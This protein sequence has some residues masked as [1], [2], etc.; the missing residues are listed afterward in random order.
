MQETVAAA[1]AHLTR[2]DPVA[3]HVAQSALDTLLSGRRLETLTQHAVQEFCWHVLPVR[4]S[5]EPSEW[6]FVTDSL[7]SLFRLL[8]LD[9]YADICV[10]ER[11]REV[12]RAYATS[13]DQG[14]AAYERSMRSSGVIPP[15]LPELT[16]GT[17][18][19]NAEIEAYRETSAVL[20]LAIAAGEVRPGTRG[21]RAAQEERARSFLTQ[22][23][24][25]GLSY[26]D[27]I[28][29]ERVAE[30]LASRSHPH[31]EHLLPLRGQLT[32]GVD[33]PRNA[34]DALAPVQRLLD[35]AAD[36]IALTQIGYISPAVVR[37]LCDEFGWWT[38]PSPPRSETD[39]MQLIVLHKLLR[40]M[41]AVR[42]SGRRL[43]L[44]RH[45]RQLHSDL[46]ELWR[47]VAESV[48]A[49][50]GFEQAAIETLL[51]VLLLR[52]P[53]SA[54]A[55]YGDADIDVADEACRLLIQ[56]GWEDDVIGGRP[57]TDQVRSVL[58]SVVWL[59]EIL[60]CITGPDLLGDGP[61]PQL[62]KVGRAFALTALHL[63]ATAPAAS[64]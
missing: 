28:R 39:V 62:T 49:T 10:S 2:T 40:A 27:K 43:V 22:P 19:G 13:H 32:A 5:S 14:L 42:R 21:W 54:S 44:T 31:R 7:S 45:G 20:E 30:W 53:Q 16:W 33:M 51:G 12:L 55:P 35:Y 47:A 36:G 34:A 56:S 15:D 61:T 17:A 60:G 57:R 52:S 38:S 48:L 1:L 25:H 23:D 58:I 26:L 9:R 41:R 63:S 29:Q 11:T 6:Q 64:L 50:D 4:F 37:A 8:D 3:A 59:L 24:H 18:L 46:N